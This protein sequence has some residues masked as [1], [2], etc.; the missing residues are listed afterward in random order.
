M[1]CFKQEIVKYK[2]NLQDPDIS[3]RD[4]PQSVIEFFQVHLVIQPYPTWEILY[5]IIDIRNPEKNRLLEEI[6]LNALMTLLDH[7]CE[8][9]VGKVDKLYNLLSNLYVSEWCMNKIYEIIV[10]RLFDLKENR[11]LLNEGESSPP[12]QC[13][14]ILVETFSSFVLGSV[15]TQS[16]HNVDKIHELRTR[17]NHREMSYEI[18]LSAYMLREGSLD[19]GNFER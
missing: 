3:A 12:E 10:P 2:R 8:N 14:V 15:I 18:F 6:V 5:H 17:K 16:T 7:I 4:L 11:G 9:Q 19:R 13:S 1:H